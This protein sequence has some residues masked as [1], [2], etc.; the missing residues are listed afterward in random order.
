LSKKF[1]FKLLHYVPFWGSLATMAFAIYLI[2]GNAFFW[3]RA[4]SVTGVVVAQK[5]TITN[6]RD[7]LQKSFK[8]IVRRE[9]SYA[10]YIKFKTGTGEEVTFLSNIGYGKNFA[11]HSGDKV[12][13]LYLSSDP[14]SAKVNSLLEMFALPLVLFVFGGIFWIV[15]IVVQYLAEPSDEDKRNSRSRG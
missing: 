15:S 11:F 1:H 14:A 13:V 2:A 10:P 6:R 3:V 9:V 7:P 5:E 12:P 4:E 8:Q